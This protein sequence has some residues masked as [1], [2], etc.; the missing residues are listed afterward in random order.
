M[1]K[2]I[3]ALVLALMMIC[4]MATTGCKKDNEPSPNSSASSSDSILSGSDQPQIV[5]DQTPPEGSSEEVSAW[6]KD[7]V[8]EPANDLYVISHPMDFGGFY[9]KPAFEITSTTY[10]VAASGF[11]GDDGHLIGVTTDGGTVIIY[12]QTADPEYP[13]FSAVQDRFYEVF[14]KEIA[15]EYIDP[16]KY[17]SAFREYDG[18]LYYIF[19]EGG[20]DTNLSNILYSVESQ[21]QSKIT[22]AAQVYRRDWDSDE[23]NEAEKVSYVRELIDNK[24]VFTTYQYIW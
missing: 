18:K 1:K 22:Y 10:Q 23:V 6:L 7:H 15:D 19:G 16:S 5:N 3:I 9:L 12:Y 2:R 21:E 20:G 24:W 8:F 13:T 11:L 4:V 14:S 17:M